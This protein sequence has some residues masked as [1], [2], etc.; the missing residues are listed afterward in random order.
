LGRSI[1]IIRNGKIVAEAYSREQNDIYQIQNIKSATKSFTGI[2]ACIALQKGI[3]DSVKQKLSDIYPEY[4][5]NHQDKKRLQL[6]MHLPCA[7]DLLGIIKM[8][9]IIFL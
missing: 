7:P 5:I 6:K 4:F 1:T 9:D 8:M 2:L 3:L